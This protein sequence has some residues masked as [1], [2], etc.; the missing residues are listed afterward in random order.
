M[1]WFGRDKST[2]Y[3][4]KLLLIRDD[5]GWRRLEIDL[6]TDVANEFRVV[7]ELRVFGQSFAIFLVFLS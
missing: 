3:Q 4:E 7:L 2:G 1:R 5:D 6:G